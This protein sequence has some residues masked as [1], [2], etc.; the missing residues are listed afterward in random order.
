[1]NL[2]QFAVL[3]VLTLTVIA[4][5]VAQSP[6]GTISGIVV[7]PSGGVIVA[8]EIVVVNDATGLQYTSKTNGEGIYVVPS[9]PPGSYRLQVSKIGFKT[10]IKPDIILNVQ[11]ALAINF[12]LPLGAASETVTVEAGAPL[13]NTESATVGTVVDRNFVENMPLNGRSFQTLLTLTPGVVLTPSNY[14]NQGQFSVNG[15]RPD[16]NYFTVDGVSANIGVAGGTGLAQT[17]GGTLPGF[18]ALGGTNTLVSVDAMQE[19]R[20]DTSSFAP[21]FGSTP[22]GQISIV[23]R[24]GTNDF[25]GTLFEYFRNDALDANNWFANRSGL[26]RPPEKQNDFGGVFGGPLRKNKTF[27]FFSYEGLRLRQPETSETIVPDAASRQMAPITIQPYLN[28]FPMP[29]GPGTGTDLAQ[30]NASYSNSSTIDAFSVRIDDTVN[31][32][33][34]VFGRYNY[35]PSQTVSRLTGTLSDNLVAPVGTQTFTLGVTLNIAKNVSNDLRVNYSN[36]RAGSEYRLDSFGGAVPLSDSQ[37]FPPGISS[38]NGSFVLDVIGPSLFLSKGKNATNE[39]RQFNVVDGLSVTSG[40]HQM[41]FGV[42]FRLLAPFSEAL[43]YEQ[44]AVFFGMTGPTGILSGISPEAVLAADQPNSLS[45]HNYS[46]Y[47]QDTWKVRPRLT[48]TYGLRWDINPPLSGRN[49]QS[50]P[51]TITGLNDPANLSLAPRGTPLYHTTYGN[52][53]PRLGVAYQLRPQVGWETV[54]RGGIG[55]FY[56]LGNGSLGNV[57]LGF[58]YTALNVLFNVP[59]PL[60]PQQ[61]MPPAFSLNPPVSALYVTVRDLD[62]PRTYQWNATL[63]QS[64]GWSQVLSFTYVGATGKDLLRRYLLSKPNAQFTNVYVTNNSG[65]SNYNALQIKYQRRLTQ[66]LQVLASYTYSHSI[67]NASDD[68]GLFTPPATASPNIDRGNSDF[69][70]RHSFTAALAYNIP[71]AAKKGVWHAVTANWALDSFVLA[72]SA[73]PVNIYGAASVV[74]GI[75]SQVRPNVV[76]GVPLYLDGP[77]YPGGK[78][79]NSAAFT[80]PAPNQQGDFGRNVLRGFGAWQADFAV[81]RQFHLTERLGLQFRAE[82]FNVFNHPNFGDPVM[83]NTLITSPLFGQSTE[84]LAS[85]LGSGGP[86]GGFNPLYQVGG[87]RSVQFALKLSF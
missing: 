64:L 18:S 65:D 56:D 85:S 69:D 81:R 58:P 35:A 33:L 82:L 70:L 9:L 6:N 87:P 26:P 40:S 22:G 19:F 55:T 73:P 80:A 84:T 5:L 57:T 47:G 37:L 86:G 48:L 17:A 50:E 31:S 60:T 24:S 63:E 41:K 67:D 15:Q 16:A 39:Q 62:L 78:A 66:G 38:R 20:I 72:R 49:S 61:A 71:A 2:R 30:F 4:P 74:A 25:H 54:L 75:E 12:T 52:V 34:S 28:A 10:L 79:F 1:V 36:Y 8:A 53:A 76:P 3:V 44:L 14:A 27:F 68:S 43:P 77:Q 59:I 13:V 45:A 7:D 32:R 11:D 46:F 21:E 42:D 83:S 29:N 51:F 23:T